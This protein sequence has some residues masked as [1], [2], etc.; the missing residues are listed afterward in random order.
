MITL[1]GCAQVAIYL[2]ALIALAKPLGA[3][4][5]RVY[6]GKP[7]LLD[8]LMRPL[9]RLV[10]RVCEVDPD[11]GM[12]WKT[13]AVAMLVFNALGMLVVYGVQ[14]LQGWLPL[15]PAGLGAVSPDSSFNTA[16]SFATNT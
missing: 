2:V 13:Y 14:R 8:P 3:F 16:I 1:N 15:N 11:E 9:E 4:M 12:T 7:T 5:A 10:Y 6:D